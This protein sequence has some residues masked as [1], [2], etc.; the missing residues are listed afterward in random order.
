MR[1]PNIHLALDGMQIE[2]AKKLIEVV[3]HLCASMKIHDLYDH[4][5]LKVVDTLKQAGAKQIWIDGKFHDIPKTVGNRVSAVV[6]NGANIITVHASGGIPM[7]EAAINAATTQCYERVADVFA[8]TLLTSLSPED[9]ARIYN[10]GDT[11]LDLARMAKEAGVQGI[12]CSPQEVGW[13]SRQ[14]DLKGMRFITPGVR[15]P[16][17]DVGDQQ[18][19][20]TPAQAVADGATDLVIGREVTT[21]ADPLAVLEKII[22]D[23][24]GTT[25]ET[26]GR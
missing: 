22:A 4:L 13:L 8:V 18:R 11:P 25:V 15:S 10:H 5:G 6:G 24:T 21:A 19:V 3:G 14:E 9:I 12:V 26:S 23:I 2:D 20:G 1:L 17:A 7:M 16:G